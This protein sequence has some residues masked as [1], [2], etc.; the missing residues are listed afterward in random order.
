ML[1]ATPVLPPQLDEYFLS[2]DARLREADLR[3]LDIAW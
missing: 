3:E 2:C 1:S